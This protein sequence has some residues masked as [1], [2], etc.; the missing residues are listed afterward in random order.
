MEYKPAA[1]IF[2]LDEPALS[3]TQDPLK[4]SL[5]RFGSLSIE[6]QVEYK[7]Y[8][9]IRFSIWSNSQAE[10]HV[11]QIVSVQPVTLT[12]T[13]SYTWLHNSAHVT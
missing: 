3:E 7:G 9:Y 4:T 10:Q 8:L 5:F 11:V 6:N 13:P 1:K 12:L 2:N